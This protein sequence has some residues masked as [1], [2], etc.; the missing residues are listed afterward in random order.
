MRVLVIDHVDSFV[1]N[2][3]EEFRVRGCEVNVVRHHA[4]VRHLVNL[5]LGADRVVLSP[6]PGHPRDAQNTAAL[7]HRVPIMTPVIGVC[8]GHQIIVEAFGGEVRGAGEVVHGKTSAIRHD[9]TGLFRGLPRPLRAG[10]YHSLAARRL[11]ES[12][13]PTATTDARIVMGVR[14]VSRPIV[15]VQFHPES[16]LTTDGGRIIDNFLQLEESHNAR[17]TG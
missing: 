13:L 12:L 6:G 4:P 14:H 8:L 5:A 1:F 11:P 7:L 9:G 3:V 2:L 17:S 10:R 15:G 16:I